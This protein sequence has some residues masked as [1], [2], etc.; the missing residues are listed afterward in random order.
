MS[1]QTRTIHQNSR[2][3]DVIALQNLLIANGAAIT[4]DGIYGAATAAA[5]REYQRAH[6]LVADG[7]AG[8]QTLNTLRGVA[9]S[10]DA[11]TLDH[12]AIEAAAAALGVD[13]ACVLAVT[14]VEARKH[15]FDA[16]G[17]PVLLFERHQFYRHLK[18]LCGEATASATYERQP[19]LCN[20]KSGGYLGGGAEWHRLQSA[21]GIHDAAALNAASYGLFQI[22]GFNYALCGFADVQAFFDAM[23]TNEAA[24]LNAFVAFVKHKSNA[25]MLKALKAHQ[26]AAFAKL[27]NGPAYAINDYDHK[28][29]AAHRRHG[30]T[31]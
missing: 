18:A 14:E 3:A 28:L 12:A 2:G 19:N 1:T 4:N 30:G 26:W 25:G 8:A 16:N 27:Y 7:I 10:H 24:Q 5:V 15:G 6:G 20:P 31:A 23:C 13:V 17:N 22:M 11:R 21:R 29:A 9:P